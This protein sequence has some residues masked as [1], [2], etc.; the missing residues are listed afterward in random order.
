MVYLKTLFLLFVLISCSSKRIQ[1]DLGFDDESNYLYQ[2]GNDEYQLSRRTGVIKT[3][4]VVTKSKIYGGSKELEKT[5]TISRLGKLKTPSGS[6]TILRPD[7]SERTVWLDGQKFSSRM[8]LDL[9]RKA[10]IVDLNSPLKEWQGRR[11]VR[12][13]KGTGV[14]CFFSQIAE[15]VKAT[16]FLKMSKSKKSGELNFH[17]IWD[18]YPFFQQQ[19]RNIQE[20]VFSPAKITYEGRNQKDETRYNLAV[21]GQNLFFHFGD[22]GD[23]RKVFWISQGVSMIKSDL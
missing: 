6:V 18:G 2:E 21:S 10:M 14:Y 3:N 1:T 12:F 22:K 20:A 4:R 7:E 11:E 16:G 5:I 19:Y 23:L 15:C 13:P 9:Q 8:K 17:V